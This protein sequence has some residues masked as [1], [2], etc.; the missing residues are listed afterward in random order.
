MRIL[1]TFAERTGRSGQPSEDPQAAF[2]RKLPDGIVLEREFVQRLPPRSMH[3]Q[4]SIDEDEGAFTMGS[5]S[6]DFTVAEDQRGA[7]L[8]AV[9]DSEQALEYVTVDES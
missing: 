5:E 4:E 2:E 9:Q 3:G 8:K 7:F 1:V 6:W